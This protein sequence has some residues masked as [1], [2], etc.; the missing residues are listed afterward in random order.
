MKAGI[1]GAEKQEVELLFAALAESKSETPVT[2]SVRGNLEFH[3]GSLHG[4]PAV[5][6]CC[7]VGKVNAALCAQILISEFAVTAIINTGSAG[8]LAEGLNVLDMV[9]CTDAVQ[10]DVDATVFGY[11]PGQVPGTDSPFFVADSRLRAAAL[12]AFARVG[13]HE[14][15]K[16]IEGRVASGDVFITDKT[17]R[18]RISSLFSPAC[19]EME[20]AAVAQVCA[21]NRV[22]FAI[23]RSVSDLAG[24]DANMSYEEFSR[25]ASQ[26][27]A[28][29]V[30]EMAAGY[31]PA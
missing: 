18:D 24:K 8:G 31:K 25:R 19:V 9:A 14:G 3:E 22:P 10:H 27:S 30:I 15:S 7:G 26:V 1:I 13:G 28:R 2:V 6:V 4:V 17:G 23:L 20:G 21:V 5:V 11:K 12:A 29:V 16:M